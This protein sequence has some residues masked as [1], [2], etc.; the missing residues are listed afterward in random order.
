MVI[1]SSSIFMQSLKEIDV[2]T[3]TQKLQPSALCSDEAATQTIVLAEDSC[4]GVLSSSLYAR[5]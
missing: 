1:R 4:P 2:H 3:A 5:M